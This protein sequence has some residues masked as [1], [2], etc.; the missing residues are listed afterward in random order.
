MHHIPT[1]TATLTI[2]STI[3]LIAVAVG[4]FQERVVVAVPVGVAEAVTGDGTLLWTAVHAVHL[5]HVLE[6]RGGV[7][8]ERG[9]EMNE[10]RDIGEV[11]VVLF[12]V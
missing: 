1:T 11:L 4:L 6:E 8:D 9:Q 3:S 2:R 12:V 5:H 7:Q 10:K